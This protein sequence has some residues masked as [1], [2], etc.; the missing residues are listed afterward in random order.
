MWHL[1]ECGVW[2]SF[3]LFGVVKYDK[4]NDQATDPPP[5]KSL[6]VPID[7]IVKVNIS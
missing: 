1:T 6:S 2:N 4:H 7:L 5:H 3:F